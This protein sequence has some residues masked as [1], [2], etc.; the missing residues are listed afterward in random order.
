MEKYDDAFVIR[1]L[2]PWNAPDVEGAMAL[3]TDD[4]L[5]EITRG[6]EPYGAVFCGAEARRHEGQVPCLR[7]DDDGGR[8]GRDQAFVPKGGWLGQ[9]C[10][11]RHSSGASSH[12]L[13]SGRA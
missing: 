9:F 3:M 8:Q 12:V 1:F 6:G 13:P 7:C 11:G 5:W 2:A 4:C 10:W